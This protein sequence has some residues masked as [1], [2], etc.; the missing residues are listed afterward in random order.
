MAG[1][2]REVFTA[3][4]RLGVTAFGGPI[5]HLGYFRT[6]FVE[7]RRWLTDEQYA[8]LMALCQ[9][10]PGP[11]SSQL[12]FALGILRAGWPGGI[13][14]FIAFTLPSALLLLAL[15]GVYPYLEGPWA[16]GALSGLKL[17][18]VTIVAHAVLGMGRQLCPDAPRILIAGSSGAILLLAGSAWM[19][20][21]VVA[22]GGLAGLWLCRQVA[23]PE[24]GMWSLRYGP[25]TGL[26]LVGAFAVLLIGLPLLAL[27]GGLWPLVEAFYRA[28]A[29]VF[30]GG[31][32]VLPL[33]QESVVA[34][35]WVESEDFLAGYGAAQAIP[36]PMFTF[37]AY[38]G[39]LAAE[40]A[41]LGGTLALLAI[42]L[43]GLLLIAGLLPLWER[44]AGIHG[45]GAV[46]AG[47]NAAVVGLLA[48]AL[49]DPIGLQG[50]ETHVDAAIALIGFSLL[51]T[52][53][54]SAIWVVLWCVT[55]SVATKLVLP[56]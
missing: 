36:G 24:P 1:S 29:L 43:P 27:A 39:A 51:A 48:A 44:L 35:G 47:V 19:Q 11:A 49:Y 9:F 4:L 12:G 34:T 6:E 5:A 25:R 10:L 37:A 21:L 33:L 23:S 54:V 52:G 16:E 42:F 56:A 13:A 7:R 20:L 31:H 46:I 28:G 41:L 3:F 40:N 15:A 38:L 22:A 45:A 50:I 26:M 14:A 8:Q 18:A 30:G 2:T 53:R 32:V 17:V 55:A